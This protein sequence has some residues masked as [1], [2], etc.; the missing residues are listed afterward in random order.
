MNENCD[1]MLGLL[2]PDGTFTAEAGYNY[3]ER[4]RIAPRIK[5]CSSIEACFGAVEKCEAERAVVPI[6]NST[7]D[8]AWVNQTLKGLRENGIMIYDEQILPVRHHLAALPGAMPEDIEYISSKDKAVQQCGMHIAALEKKLGKKLE[9]EYVNS[10]AASAQRIRDEN[11]KNHAAIVSQRAVD[12]YGLDILVRDMQ[13]DKANK[14]RFI[15]IS[16]YDH[17][18]TGDDKTT[19]L[20]EFKDAE[21]SGLL[22]RILSE[23]SARGI[24]LRYI[25]SL[26]KDGSLDNFTFYCDIRGHREGKCLKEAVEAVQRNPDIIYFKIMGSYPAYRKT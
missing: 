25:Q 15:I 24:S 20:W 6:L 7:T 4:M 13:D 16:R 18:P 9:I 17:E 14:T 3:I 1:M 12:I 11:L 19:V 22:N 5:W 8:A 23:F 21:D 26:P 2:G 10:T